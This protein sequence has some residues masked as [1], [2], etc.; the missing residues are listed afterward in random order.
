MSHGDVVTK[1]AG[2]VCPV[3]GVRSPSSIIGLME[4]VAEVLN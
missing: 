4:R 1:T 3:P 2:D